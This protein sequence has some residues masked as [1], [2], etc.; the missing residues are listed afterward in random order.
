MNFCNTSIKDQAFVNK[1][2]TFG[3]HPSRRVDKH[4]K[5]SRHLQS[6]KN[7]Q[8]Y[9]ELAKKHT[10]VWKIIR[11]ANLSQAVTKVSNNRYMIKCFFKRTFYL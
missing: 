6:V 10:D 9:D 3:D 5:S 11:D 8:A 4:L 1:A 7:K 2:C